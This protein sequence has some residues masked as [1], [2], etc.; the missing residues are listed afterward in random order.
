MIF[1]CIVLYYFSLIDHEKKNNKN[2]YKIRSY[3]NIIK[4]IKNTYKLTDI[5]TIKKIQKLNFT[6]H[7]TNKLFDILHNNIKLPTYTSDKY[8]KILLKF[9]LMELK[10]I[11]P[12]KADFLINKG[13]KNVDNLKLKKWNKFLPKHVI[14]FL[15]YH[16]KIITYNEATLIIKII[17]KL[18]HHEF[19]NKNEMFI[20][21]SYRRK[22]QYNINDLD[23]VI[24]SDNNY[25]IDLFI[26][27]LKNQY[28]LYCINS[29]LI[30]RQ[31]LLNVKHILKKKNNYFVKID[32][33]HTYPKNKWATILYTTG[34][35]KFNIALRNKIKRINFSKK[36]KFMLNQYGLHIIN[37]K[38]IILN[39]IHLKNESHLF[40]LLNLHY[41]SPEKR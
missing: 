2:I 13:L 30:K 28:E 21:G 36:N 27:K 4:K 16:P 29:G 22:K 26:K 8:N 37:K 1:L 32:F 15:K 6:Q 34:S 24:S 25:I 41:I 14:L 10:G 17:K 11:G 12:H 40:D 7:T 20:T 33:F 5:V 19:K 35:K 39:T 31:I 18:F 38:N 3:E 9:K 23:I